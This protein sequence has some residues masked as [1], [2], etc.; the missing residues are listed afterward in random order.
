MIRRVAFVLQQPLGR[1]FTVTRDLGSTVSSWNC[2]WNA[3]A[4]ST[5]RESTP[6][7]GLGPNIESLTLVETPSE[8]F[9]GHELASVIAEGYE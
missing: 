3:T 9:D 6:C 1:A 5:A 7:P 2:H 8:P 4:L